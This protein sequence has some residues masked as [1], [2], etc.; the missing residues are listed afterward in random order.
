MP[1]FS[2]NV[3]ELLTGDLDQLHIRVTHIPGANVMPGAGRAFCAGADME[4]TF[5]SRID[6][7]DPGED[8]ASGQGGDKRP[9][10][11]R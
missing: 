9:P 4:L 3:Y 7:R 1:T 8:T 5:K 11:F 6:G 10:R 2:E